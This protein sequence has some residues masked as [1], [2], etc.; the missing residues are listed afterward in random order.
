MK[1]LNHKITLNNSRVLTR[2][3]FNTLIAQLICGSFCLNGFAQI[4]P[5][6]WQNIKPLPQAHAHNDYEHERPLWDALSHGFTSIEVDVFPVEGELYVAHNLPINPRKLPTLKDLYLTPLQKHITNYGAIYP[7]YKG[8]FFLMID[9]KQ[10]GNEAF[11]LLKEEL[12]DFSGMLKSQGG[13]VG[14]FLSGA[15]PISMAMND[16]DKWLAIDGRPDDLDKDYPSELMPV[17]S[18]RYGKLISWRGKGE[19]PEENA[20]L[21]RSICEKAHKQG[22]KVRLWASTEKEKVWETLLELGV[23]YINTDKL[24]ELAAFFQSAQ[25]EAK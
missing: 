5:S 22:K 1:K 18:Q 20:K 13:P 2:G 21:I 4:S 12:K 17:I 16:P 9:I 25:Y 10:D 19:I 3:I 14:I 23:D 7:N 11:R 15:R 24:A 6:A 8:D